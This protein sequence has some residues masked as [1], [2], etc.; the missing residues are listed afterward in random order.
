[1]SKEWEKVATAQRIA[2]D[3]NSAIPNQCPISGVCK[4]TIRDIYDVEREATFLENGN[5]SYADNWEFCKNYTD[6]GVA[7]YTFIMKTYRPGG[8]DGRYIITYL[9]INID[10]MIIE[11]IENPVLKKEMEE[12]SLKNLW[13][14]N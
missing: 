13:M 1:M 3:I 7:Y 5:I 2:E 6:N 10:P 4:R 12:H 8:W 9:N 11:N 14:R